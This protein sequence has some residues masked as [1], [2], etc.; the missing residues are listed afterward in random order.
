MADGF[1]RLAV[2]LTLESPLALGERKPGGQAT[3]SPG[4]LPGARLRG[5]VA[6]LLLEE[7]ICPPAHRGAHAHCASADCPLGALFGGPAA[8]VFRDALPGASDLAADVLPAT[9]VSCK[10]HPG[11]RSA[12][13]SDGAHGVYDT[14]LDRAFLETLNPAGLL[15]RP[16]CADPGC[17]AWAERFAGYYLAR[18][19]AGTRRHSAARTPRRLLARV[20]LDRRRRVAADELLYTVPVLSEVSVGEDG[21]PRPTVFQGEVL[22]PDDANG[23]LL[24][25]A[26][27]RVDHLG[28]GGSRGLGAVRIATAPAPAPDSLAA[29]LERFR[30]AVARRREQYARLAPLSVASLEGVYFS[31][32]LRSDALLRRLGW[33]PTTVLDADLL[34]AATRVDD[35]SLTLVR[36]YAEPDWRG[37]WQAAWGLPRPT[38]LVAR[39]GSC[40][41]FRTAN[42]AA[43]TAALEALEATGLGVRTAEGYGEVRVCDPFHL[44]LREHAV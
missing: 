39:R 8:A 24:V 27:G 12:L 11:F 35:P 43:W 21:V 19:V 22:V 13:H 38:E 30:G 20:A 18:G 29:R 7:G 16:R 34:R 23:T 6:E 25:E 42:P 10:R 44:V 31:I 5:A 28:G 36:A 4:Y 41:L 26:L 14:L 40:Y 3:H 9:A 15:Y 2:T 32:D 33:E 17:G 37:G 1:R